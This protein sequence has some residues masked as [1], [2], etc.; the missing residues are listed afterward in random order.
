MNRDEI[1]LMR[2]VL[3]QA[4]KSEATA[5]ASLWAIARLSYGLRKKKILSDAEIEE[6]FDPS[7]TASSIQK[8]LQSVAF[9]AIEHLR[10]QSLGRVPSK[11]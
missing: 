9:Q 5:A 7:Q 8:E 10:D 4:I 3:A 2:E 1:P 11:H 6:L